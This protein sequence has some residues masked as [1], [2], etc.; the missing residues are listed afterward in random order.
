MHPRDHYQLMARYNQ[1]MNGKLYACAEPLGDAARRRDLGAFFGSVHGT[2]DHLL[3]GDSAWMGRFTGA[4]SLPV[5][6][7]TMHADFD[8]MRAA[9]Q[10]LDERIVAWS[11]SLTDAWLARDF[12]YNSSVDNRT[13][14][15]PAWTLV[16][17]MFNHQTH[18]RGQVT[19]LLKQ[20]GADPGVTDLPW[21]LAP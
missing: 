13:R 11:A 14:T 18:H 6:G 7:E 4:S 19:T 21:L 1:W 3:Y 2:L 9:R 16:T 20:L 15:L 12:T 10:A 5:L 8:A 17:H